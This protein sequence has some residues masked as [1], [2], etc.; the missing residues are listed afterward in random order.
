MEQCWRWYGPND[1]VTLDHV[2][3]AGATGVVSALHDIYDGRTWPLESI[4]ERKRVIE[5]AG[6]TWSV[7]E[8]IPVH[9]S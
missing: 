4:L 5:A 8:S 7:V 2:R 6:L 3:Q 1:P 9:N